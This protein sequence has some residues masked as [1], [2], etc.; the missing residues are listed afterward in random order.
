MQLLISNLAWKKNELENVLKFLKKKKI[1]NLE[2]S[3][4]NLFKHQPKLKKIKEIKD[5]W[6][7]KS[8]K[9]YSMQSILYKVNDAYIFGNSRQQNIFYSEVINKIKIAHYLNAKIIIF[10]SPKNKKIFNRSQ[11]ECNDLMIKFL[12]KISPICEKYKITLCL[13]SNP[14]IYKTEFLTKTNEAINLIKKIKSKYIKLNL[15][16]GTIISNKE[17]L[18]DIVKQNIKI[19]GHVQISSPFLKNLSKYKIKIKKL[20][21]CLKNKNYKKKISIEMLSEKENNL[22]L[23]KE[24][25]EIIDVKNN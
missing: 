12:K 19:I 18:N 20:V 17:N 11:K 8:I 7:S 25:F 4:H 3:L 5:F 16:L 10:G 6:N 9:F 1:K 2:F 15:D 14:K 23:I 22:S 21:K 24:I 13:E